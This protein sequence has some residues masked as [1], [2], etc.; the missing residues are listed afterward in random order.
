MVSLMD[1]KFVTSSAESKDFDSGFSKGMLT[2]A[3]LMCLV[4]QVN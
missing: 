4:A 2:L 3:Q 1:R